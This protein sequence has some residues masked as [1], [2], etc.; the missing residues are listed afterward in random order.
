MSIYKSILEEVELS[1]GTQLYVQIN[2][3]RGSISIDGS[4]INA[5]CWL[6]LTEL[7]A[8]AIAINKALEQ[9]NE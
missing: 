7:K 9:A 3:K 8:Y 1:T 2:G 6:T 5:S 4:E